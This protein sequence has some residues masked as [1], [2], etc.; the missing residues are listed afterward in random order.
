VKKEVIFAF[1]RAIEAVL[2]ESGITSMHIG[3]LTERPRGSTP[4]SFEVSISIGVAGALR[5][6]MFLQADFL[7]AAELAREISFRLG[8]PLENPEIFG[9]MHKAA[10]AELANQVSGRA[11]MYLADLGLDTNITPPTILTGS[12]IMMGVSDQ[13]EFHD[14]RLSGPTSELNLVV[15]LQAS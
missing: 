4:R 10:L 2:S 12:G 13:L 5:G 6:F 8:V 14:A 11:T 15:G 7:S 1:S 3:P 9:A